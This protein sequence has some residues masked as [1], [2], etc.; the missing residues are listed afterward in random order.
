[1]ELSANANKGDVFSWAKKNRLQEAVF[2][3]VREQ[4]YLEALAM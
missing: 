4:L 2:L 3:T 1:M